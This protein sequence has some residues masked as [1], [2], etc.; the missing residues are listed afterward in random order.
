MI[1]LKEQGN[2]K[3]LMLQ[4]TIENLDIGLD[5]QGRAIQEETVLIGWL[6]KCLFQA[7]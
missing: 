7:K 4:N 1:F 2:N 3:S 5:S 6:F